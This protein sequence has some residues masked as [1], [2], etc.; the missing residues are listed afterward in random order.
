DRTAAAQQPAPA[1]TAT[2]TA[3][4]SSLGDISTALE[5]LGLPDEVRALLTAEAQSPPTGDVPPV[6]VDMTVSMPTPTVAPAQAVN[7]TVVPLSSPALDQLQHQLASL[8]ADYQAAQERIRLDY[9]RRLA[10]DTQR[11]GQAQQAAWAAYYQ[12]MAELEA[13][14]Q[15][16]LA[17]W[18]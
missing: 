15:H 5:S 6:S 14:Y 2:S 18:G 8:D 17:E 9:A 13:A 10:H 4:E 1:T 12:A 3:S 11:R 16:A 7:S